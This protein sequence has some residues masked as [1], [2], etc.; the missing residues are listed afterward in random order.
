MR[1]SK[2]I[3]RARLE[4]RLREEPATTYRSIPSLGEYLLLVQN[5]VINDQYIRGEDSD[6]RQLGT[7]TNLRGTPLLPS[8]HATLSIASIWRIP[9]PGGALGF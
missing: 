1:V 8:V 3:G 7:F 2:P 9:E 5:R 6:T 4:M